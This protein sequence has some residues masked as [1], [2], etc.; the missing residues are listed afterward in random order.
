MNFQLLRCVERK[1]LARRMKLDTY[2]D[3]ESHVR[4]QFSLTC[5]RMHAVKTSTRCKFNHHKI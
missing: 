3:I 2:T 4:A 1:C 5:T